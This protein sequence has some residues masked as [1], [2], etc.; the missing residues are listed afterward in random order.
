MDVATTAVAAASSM[1]SGR[2][3]TAAAIPEPPNSTPI[4]TRKV[5]AVKSPSSVGVISR[6]STMYV[7]SVIPRDRMNPLPEKLIP[8]S[9]VPVSPGWRSG[10]LMRS[11]AG[12]AGT[13]PA[14]HGTVA[15]AG[16]SARP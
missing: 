10:A 6:A 5:P 2:W 12:G 1:R 14:R 3:M 11:G 15:G 4:A 13:W 9:T 16:R 7:T 8:R